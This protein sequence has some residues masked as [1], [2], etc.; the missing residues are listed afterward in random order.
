M[1]WYI[2]LTDK[3]ETYKISKSKNKHYK[4]TMYIPDYKYWEIHSY[5]PRIFSNLRTI[6]YKKDVRILA[7]V[8]K[9]VFPYPVRTLTRK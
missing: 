1:A 8:L 9:V 5:S 3:K 6:K 2:R 7:S 4:C